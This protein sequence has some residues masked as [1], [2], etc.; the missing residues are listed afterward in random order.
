[1]FP[2]I[3]ASASNTELGKTAERLCSVSG[4]ISYPLY[5]FHYPVIRVVCFIINKHALGLPTL[6]ALG[7]LAICALCGVSWLL[8]EFFDR[9]A[10]R[11]LTK[12]L[13]TPANPVLAVGKTV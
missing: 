1:V 3:I 5:A 10:R 9:P 11:T 8:F 7:M 13:L 2:L 4:A 6:L 12:Y